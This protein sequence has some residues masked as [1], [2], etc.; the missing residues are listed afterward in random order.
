MY[1]S[2]N[3]HR[4]TESGP[5]VIAD[6]GD[7]IAA[8]QPVLGFH[9]TDSLLV[10]GLQGTDT[11]VISMMVRTD[12]PSP[13][14]HR[15][16]A[17]NL[18]QTLELNDIDAVVL[19]VVG[20]AEGDGPD[21]P[22]RALLAA[23]DEEFASAGIGVVEQLWVADT[24]GNESWRCYQNDNCGGPVPDPR[25]TV[26]AAHT[27]AA[28]V[29]LHDQ[30]DDLVATLAP[31]DEDVLA[32]RAQLLAA[33]DE[34]NSVRGLEDLTMLRAAIDRATEG[35]L[36]ES[37]A[38]F[39]ALARALANHTVRDACLA[40]EDARRSAAAERLWT[41]LVRGLP[42][43]ERAEPACLLSFAAYLRGDGGLASIALDVAES[44]DPHHQLAELLRKS[45][46]VGLPPARLRKVAEEA[47]RY[48][49]ATLGDP[50]L[51]DHAAAPSDGHRGGF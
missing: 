32:Q 30:R 19:L 47:S 26:L 29:V 39:V 38:E 5:I 50:S 42:T 27:V 3:P 6:P 46:R 15:L 40:P 51:Q 1:S 49:R 2:H 21:L 34:Y 43:P 12:L 37:D 36:P 10:M 14:D 20:G 45:I 4:H 18:T 24:R 22:H 35:Q 11:T 33:P 13:D 28:G 48:S 41:R 16:L 25:S 17:A 23:C 8:V 31:A 44:A 7:L 9:P